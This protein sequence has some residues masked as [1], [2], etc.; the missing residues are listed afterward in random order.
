VRSNAKQ[1]GQLID[2]LLSF[3]QLARH[4]IGRQ[5]FDPRPLVEECFDKLRV[6][7]GN[8]AVQCITGVLPACDA[9]PALL[10]QVFMNLI[11]NAFKYSAKA[12][13]PR[14][15]VGYE[16]HGGEEA[17]FVRDNGVG[18][19]MKYAGKLFGVFQRLHRQ[20]EF[21]G[22]GVGL[23]IVQRIVQRHGG[24]VWAQAA[25]GEGAMFYFTLAE[26]DRPA[27]A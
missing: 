9:D 25:P 22:T 17:Y 6:Q 12:E 27:R 3:A 2:D 26:S 24:R 18:F 19:D 10:R 21:E 20:E 13:R 4:E 14:V 23:A 16:R 15:Q 11:G 1:M 7:T 8:Q 5:R